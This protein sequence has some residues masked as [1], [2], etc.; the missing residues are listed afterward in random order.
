MCGESSLC[1]VKRNS[2]GLIV[3]VETVLGVVGVEW[4]EV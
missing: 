3:D 4:V 2:V 1:D